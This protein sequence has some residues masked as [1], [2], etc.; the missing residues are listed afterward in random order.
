MA[1]SRAPPLSQPQSCLALS[2]RRAASAPRAALR[3]VAAARGTSSPDGS[4]SPS[5]G[6]SLLPGLFRAATAREP[7]QAGS[8]V[9]RD[10]ARQLTRDELLSDKV[11]GL[12]EEM[13]AVSRARGV[14][15]AAPQLGEPLAL[16]VLEDPAEDVPAE[17]ARQQERFAFGLKVLANP[18]V[19]AKPGSAVAH[20]FE[21][22]LSVQGY[23][24]LVPRALEVDV[25]ALGGDGEPVAFSAR[26]WLARV[27]QHEYDHLQGT[28]YVDRM[29]SRSFRRL[30][31]MD[32]PLPGPSAEFGA[33]PPEGVA[34]REGGG[35]AAGGGGRPPPRG[36]GTGGRPI[37]R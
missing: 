33:C 36:P 6:G 24:A 23:R 10:K 37:K 34:A 26:G 14:G 5:G 7:V 18:V 28:L 32:K 30:D 29:V 16:I 2:R 15:L 27:L 21:G 9:L 19:K 31:L 22:C 13:V 20:F 11:Q 35:G 17:E 8:P 1:L 4:W 3:C 12:I 25:T